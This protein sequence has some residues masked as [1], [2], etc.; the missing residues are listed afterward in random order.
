[1]EVSYFP[2][3]IKEFISLENYN[4]S[5]YPPVHSSCMQKLI[6]NFL[7]GTVISLGSLI[8][9]DC[10]NNDHIAIITSINNDKI[11]DQDQLISKAFIINNNTEWK[12]ISS[13]YDGYKKIKPIFSNNILSIPFE[14]CFPSKLH[15][16]NKIKQEFGGYDEII[17]KVISLINYGLEMP[18]DSKFSFP[19]C[20]LFTGINGTG[21]TKLVQLISYYS[22]LPVYFIDGAQCMHSSGIEEE[23]TRSIKEI[24]NDSLKHSPS[25]IFIDQLENICPP[26]SSGSSNGIGSIESHLSV[27]VKNFLDFIHY[28]PLDDTVSSNFNKQRK[29]FVLATCTNALHGAIDESFLRSGRFDEIFTLNLPSRK[30]RCEILKI[31][32]KSIPLKE[33]IT[34]DELCNELSSVTHGFVAADL[35]AV[36]NDTLIQIIQKNI[37]NKNE[38]KLLNENKHQDDNKIQCKIEDFLRVSK[39]IRPANLAEHVKQN[40]NLKENLISFK[41]FGGLE[42]IINQLKVSVIHGIQN[43]EIYKKL[44]ISSPNGILFY[45]PSGTGKTQ[46]VQALANESG[47]NLITIQ[48]PELIS[49]VVGQSEKNITE[50]FYKARSSAPCILFLDQV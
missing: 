11:K 41:D 6:G 30:Q 12:F 23:T 24:L 20:F 34:N 31:L 19:H 28:Q 49:P 25:I 39:M 2:T 35:E 47:L 38:D 10:F 13:W 48:G 50:I 7:I 15:W 9:I 16:E 37:E 44:G 5:H 32:S 46:M 27:I 8:H 21:K 22:K 42:K 43:I 45:G 14:I 4:P 36:C 18:N 1:M 17:E 40:L 26:L 29:V 33:G 3:I